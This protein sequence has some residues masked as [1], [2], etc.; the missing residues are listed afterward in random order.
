MRKCRVDVRNGPLMPV[1]LPSSASLLSLKGPKKNSRGAPFFV[2]IFVPGKIQKKLFIF[3][4][5]WAKCS[6]QIFLPFTTRG[7]AFFLFSMESIGFVKHSLTVKW[8]SSSPL[9][10]WI[11]MSHNQNVHCAAYMLIFWLDASDRTLFK[12]RRPLSGGINW[13]PNL[14]PIANQWQPLELNT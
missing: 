5:A 8:L 11:L 6:F 13:K 3:Y 1:F 14:F 7:H 12:T 2:F 9:V 10:K 4:M